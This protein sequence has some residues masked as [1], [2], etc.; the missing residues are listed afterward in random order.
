MTRGANAEG[1][2]T[3]SSKPR[4][5]TSLL[6]NIGSCCLDRKSW[7]RGS[8]WTSVSNSFHP[9][10][11]DKQTADSDYRL[12]FHFVT[13]RPGSRMASLVPVGPTGRVQNQEQ[14]VTESAIDR[15]SCEDKL[16]MSAATCNSSGY[17]QLGGESRRNL[18]FHRICPLTTHHPS[19]EGY[20]S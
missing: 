16:V 19:P 5:M 13:P 6:S 17:L 10:H 9:M 12:V 20:I 1:L 15:L 3:S 7:N 18:L 11:I 4:W 2:I 14:I 8:V